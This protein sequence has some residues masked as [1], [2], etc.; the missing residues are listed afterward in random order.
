MILEYKQDVVPETI[1]YLKRKLRRLRRLQN[2]NWNN[3]KSDSMTH[4]E[5]DHT[6]WEIQEANIVAMSIA[7]DSLK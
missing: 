6:I 2:I 7:A 4:H 5:W 1:V 3:G